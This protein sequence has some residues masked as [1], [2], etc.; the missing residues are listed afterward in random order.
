MNIRHKICH[1]YN[2]YADF[3]SIFLQ[4]DSLHCCYKCAKFSSPCK[5]IFI[6]FL[7]FVFSFMGQLFMDDPK[8]LLKRDLKRI[9]PFMNKRMS[10]QN[11]HF[12][13]WEFN[14]CVGKSHSWYRSGGED[15]FCYNTR[16]SYHNSHSDGWGVWGTGTQKKHYYRD[17]YEHEKKEP[18]SGSTKDCHLKAAKKPRK[19]VGLIDFLTTPN[20][21]LVAAEIL[22]I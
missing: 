11:S 4:K 21:E 1:I 18:P 3:E 19:K 13:V 10:L 7:H 9:S 8:S 17:L 12:P 20:F 2:E 5:I 15:C 6:F 14:N 16:H 22:G